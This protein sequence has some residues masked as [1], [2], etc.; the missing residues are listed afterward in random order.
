[1]HVTFNKPEHRCEAFPKRTTFAM[2]S[3]KQPVPL[4]PYDYRVEYLRI[5]ATAQNTARAAEGVE[6]CLL[7][8]QRLLANLR[9]EDDAQS[10]QGT[11]RIFVQE[12]IVAQVRQQS[13]AAHDHAYQAQS[14]A[15]QITTHPPDADTFEA[16]IRTRRA[17]QAVLDREWQARRC[18]DEAWRLI[19]WLLVRRRH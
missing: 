3:D 15:R 10:G 7:V 12:R 11:E 8:A 14:L 6:F 13:A 2:T 1:M 9:N 19:G 17:V 16:R 18:R 5:Q 4:P